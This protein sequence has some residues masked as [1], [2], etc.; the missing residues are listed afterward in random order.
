MDHQEVID[1]VAPVI[2]DLLKEHRVQ[3]ERLRAEVGDLKRWIV[4]LRAKDK[5]RTARELTH[6]A[7]VEDD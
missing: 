6:A 3:I 7:E 4:L 1:V 5:A 2:A